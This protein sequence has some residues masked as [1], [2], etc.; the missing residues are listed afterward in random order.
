MRMRKIKEDAATTTE[1][2]RR[3]LSKISTR[4]KAHRGDGEIKIAELSKT[5]QVL[6]KKSDIH[7]EVSIARDEVI[8]EKMCAHNLS[9]ELDSYRSMLQQEQERVATLRKEC[10]QLKA[11][12]DSSA[13][14]Q[15][16]C[17][18]PGFDPTSLIELFSG[19][20]MWLQRALRKRESEAI[21]SAA[22]HNTKSSKKSHSGQTHDDMD[23]SS[24]S[25][26][27]GVSSDSGLLPGML[28]DMLH[29]INDP[30]KLLDALDVSLMSKKILDQDSH[31]QA[32]TAKCEELEKKLVEAEVVRGI[33]MSD[34]SGMEQV[35]IHNVALQKE[36]DICRRSH[37]QARFDLEHSQRTLAEIETALADCRREL[38]LTR[39]RG[40]SDA[41]DGE[42]DTERCRQDAKQSP[43]PKCS[44]LGHTLRERTAQVQLH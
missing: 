34:S 6:S 14:V 36:L 42:S 28:H 24:E 7:Q 41:S 22:P 18:I 3:E 11:S 15:S 29:H 26:K 19:R 38:A 2:L 33:D 13:V 4:E 20:I 8:T 23:A 31:I 25:T 10:S 12:L 37:S 35:M 17:F 39:L 1:A 30:E 27:L 16:I 44:D 43:C 32:M 21:M 40:S 9:V 5:I